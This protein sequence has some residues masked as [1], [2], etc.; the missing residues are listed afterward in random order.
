MQNK[1]YTPEIEEFH[2]GFECEFKSYKNNHQGGSVEQWDKYVIK[3]DTFDKESYEQ[4]TYRTNWRVKYLNE[5]DI[6]SLGFKHIGGKLISGAEQEYHKNNYRLYYSTDSKK[7]KIINEDE[8]TSYEVEGGII[9]SGKIK[10]KT[11][12]KKL[13][14]QLDCE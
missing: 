14:K 6:I 8:N 2:V 4:I 3:I 11:E 5:D 12:F 7:L 13:L 1:Y 9:F 10:N